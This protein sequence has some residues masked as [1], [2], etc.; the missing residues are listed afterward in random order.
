MEL[1]RVME[2][3]I[4]VEITKPTPLIF[5]ELIENIHPINSWDPGKKIFFCHCLKINIWPMY[6]R[7][8]LDCVLSTSDWYI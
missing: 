4:N 2:I 3:L 5:S 1:L 6:T 7:I 8:N